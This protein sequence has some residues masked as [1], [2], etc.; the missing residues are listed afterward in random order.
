MRTSWF[1]FHCLISLCKLPENIL[2]NTKSIFTLYVYYPYYTLYNT[3]L[4]IGTCFRHLFEI[5]LFLYITQCFWTLATWYENKPLIKT[6]SLSAYLKVSKA[7]I[8]YHMQKKNDRSFFMKIKGN[9]WNI[10]L[11]AIMLRSY[12]PKEKLKI[13]KN[14]KTT[15]F[16]VRN[17]NSLL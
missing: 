8:S 15:T 14:S 5:F 7:L 1:L 10:F 17:S 13:R 9:F 16:C 11:S 2:P 6:P 4:T 3:F 12:N